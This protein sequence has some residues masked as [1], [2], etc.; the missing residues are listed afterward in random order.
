MED[1]TE[2][3][4]QSGDRDCIARRFVQT[5]HLDQIDVKIAADGEVDADSAG[6]RESIRYDIGVFAGAEEL[7]ETFAFG[8]EGQRPAGLQRQTG[9][10]FLNDRSGLIDDSNRNNRLPLRLRRHRLRRCREGGDRKAK[11][12]EQDPEWPSKSNGHHHSLQDE[13]LA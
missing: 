11:R 13:R 8:V 2:A 9:W 12:L 1:F 10:V 6:D 5:L 4:A 7:A 3:D